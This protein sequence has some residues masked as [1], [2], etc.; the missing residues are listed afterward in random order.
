MRRAGATVLSG[1]AAADADAD[2]DAD[3]RAA[4]GEL[5][6]DASGCFLNLT[7]ACLPT[8]GDRVGER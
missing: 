7:L 5:S 6:A 3:A 8:S 4:E 1:E 2:A